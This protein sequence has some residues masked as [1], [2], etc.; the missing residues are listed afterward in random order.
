MDGPLFSNLRWMLTELE[1]WC[2]VC[3]CVWSAGLESFEYFLCARHSA[4]PSESPCQ[5]A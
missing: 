1:W 3:V 5:V 4:G 2:C